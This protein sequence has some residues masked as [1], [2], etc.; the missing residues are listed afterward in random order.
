[1]LIVPFFISCYR[2]WADSPPPP[3]S[4]ATL[5]GKDERSRILLS[6]FPHFALYLRGKYYYELVAP[7]FKTTLTLTVTVFSNTANRSK[8]VGRYT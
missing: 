6:C 3:P 5:Q 4:E 2:I 7:R 1:M 8:R